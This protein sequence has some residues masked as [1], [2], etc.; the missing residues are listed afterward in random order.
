MD[1]GFDSDKYFN[2]KSAIANEINNNDFIESACI[3]DNIVYNKEQINEAMYSAGALDQ[4]DD[5]EYTG[6]GI[7]VGIMETVLDK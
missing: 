2:H 7:K 5:P 3:K 4:Y 1:I 6:R